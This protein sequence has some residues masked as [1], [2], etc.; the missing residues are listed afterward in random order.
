MPALGL[1]WVGFGAR[2]ALVGLGDGEA[3]R[4]NYSLCRLF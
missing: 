4:A 3:S 2:V 1:E